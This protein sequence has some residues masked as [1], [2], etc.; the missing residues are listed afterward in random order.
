MTTKGSMKYCVTYRKGES[1][2][3]RIVEANSYGCAEEQVMADEPDA[4]H[5]VSEEHYDYDR[6][7]WSTAITNYLD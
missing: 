4:T 3:E 1:I 2:H 7:D 6:R 5:V